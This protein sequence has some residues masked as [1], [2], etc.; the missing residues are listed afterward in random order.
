MEPNAIIEK[1]SA[2]AANYDENNRRLAP[3][4]DNMHFLVR[5]ILRDLPH[6][7]RVLCIG[8][9]TGAEILSLAASFP[10]WTFV[11]VDPSEGMLEVCRGR[12]AEAGV[13]ER[14]VLL[15]GFLHDLPEEEGFDAALSILVGHFIVREDRVAHYEG[16]HR[17]LVPRGIMVNTELSF[18][19]DSPESPSMLANWASVQALPGGAAVP[20][21]TL[22]SQMRQMLTIVPPGE[23]EDLLRRAGFAVPVRFFQSLLIS[24][25]Y[26]TK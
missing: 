26:G 8:V 10:S 15:R 2:T 4:A 16:L 18:D 14:C 21:A 1:F 22:S 23:T 11:G 17:R 19:L 5:T 20:V 12:L 25:W 9:G 13:L 6:S 7:A 3:I 24:G